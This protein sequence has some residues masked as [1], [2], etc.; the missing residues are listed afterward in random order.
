MDVDNYDKRWWAW[1]S[2]VVFSVTILGLW[3]A[4]MGF[5]LS[6]LLVWFCG[7]HFWNPSLTTPVLELTDRLCRSAM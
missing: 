7:T 2:A 6:M 3:I 1:I 5:S 4:Y